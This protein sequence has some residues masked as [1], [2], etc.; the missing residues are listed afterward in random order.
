M[1]LRVF[2]AVL[3]LL[4]AQAFTV[5][6][7]APVDAPGYPSR[8]AD[9]DALPG[10]RNPPAG[11]GQVPFW[12]WSG[13]ALDPERLIWQLRELH[14]KGVSG[15]QV[16][17]SHTDSPGW[18]SDLKGPEIFSE[19]WWE[20]YTKVADECGRLGMGI[21]LSTYTLDWPSGGDNL[22]RKLF[23]DQAELNAIELV[24]SQHLVGA[25]ETRTVPCVENAFAAWAYRMRGG[26]LQ[27]GGTD[28]TGFIENGALTW[29]APTDGTD[30]ADDW[31]VWTFGTRRKGGSL[32]PLM[33]GAGATVVRGFYQQFED[34]NKGSSEGL[35]YFFNDE[36]KIG[37][38]K[39]AW[40]PDFHVE[41]FRRKGY[42]L[43]DVLP[44]MWADMGDVTPKARIDY[45][46]LRMAL[47]EERYFEPIYAWHEKRGIIFGC[48]NHGRGLGPQAY[49]DYFRATRWYSA[50][51]HDTP[52][53][54]AGV[55]KGK[56]SS[57][58]AKLYQRP[59][60]W[61][62]AYHSLGWGATPERLMFATRENYLYGCTLLNLHGL[63]YSTYGSRW[64]WAPPSYHFRM[65]YWKHMGT[66]L[67]YFE[68][69]SYLM[70]QGDAVAD[71]AVI[72]PVTP[73]EAETNG[74]EA[75]DT[76]FQIGRQLMAA[77][78]S[79]DF[80]D[81]QSLSRAVVEDGR[82]LVEDARASYQALVLPNMEAARWSTLEKAAAFS[83]ARGLVLSVGKLPAATDR[84][85]RNDP[86]LAPLL[87]R[88]VAAGRRLGSEGELVRVL[89]SAFV[90]DI[91]GLNGTVRALHRKVGPRDVY[92]VMDAAP[93]DVVE[94]RARGAVELWDAWTGETE[95]LRVVEETASGT[96]VELPLEKYEAQLVVFDP[97]REHVDP[98]QPR[99]T[100]HPL[101][102][103]PDT[104][105]Q[106]AFLPTMD[107]RWGD[108]RLPVTPE[109]R[110]IGVEARRF[111]WL[112]DDAA[113]PPAAEA[114]W[115]SQLHGHGPQMLLHKAAR[116]MT[117][118]QEL[119]LSR[120][121]RPE[122]GDWSPYEFSWRHGVE[123][124]PGH[125]GWHGNKGKVSEHFLRVGAVERS[126]NGI[127]KLAAEEG[128]QS[129]YFWTQAIAPEDCQAV[130]HLSQAAESSAGY[131][132]PNANPVLAPAAIYLNGRRIEDPTRPVRLEA[133]GNSLLVRF[134]GH[135]EGHLVL[136]R[137]D[138]AELEPV[139]ALPLA[140]RWHP[141]LQ[142]SSLIRFDPFVGTT[143]AEPGTGSAQWF[144]FVTAPGTTAITI[145]AAH[146][147]SP[148][149][150]FCDGRPMH[151]GGGGRHRVESPGAGAAIIDLRLTPPLGCHGGAALPEPITI[152]T[153]GRG[154]MALGDWSQRGVLNN[155][156]GA[157]AYTRHL[158]L[159]A[160]EAQRIT[161]LDLGKV[162]ATAELRVNGVEAGVRVAPPWRFDVSGLL[163]AGEN[164]LTVTVYNTL[165]NHYQT[166]PNQYRGQPVAGLF[167]PVRLQGE[168]GN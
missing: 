67:N 110:M 36:L 120:S 52:G 61:L 132:T 127:Q 14:A 140:M 64:E 137:T 37:L 33:A 4:L 168:S 70:S 87:D 20:I 89:R 8:A 43:F 15:V 42:N 58:I 103:L 3:I 22:F 82:L 133:G 157:V 138:H 117:L 60:V 90:Q 118:Q 135:G 16:N 114:E 56:V 6:V 151:A 122:Q 1:K 72:Y 21:G 5:A 59:R 93:G 101:M 66:F 29:S 106:V 125:Q 131:S 23:Y 86:L 164:T 113:T 147:T 155:Y 62:E 53:G 45:A 47:M 136:R 26:L 39:L 109:N 57:S 129:Y 105:W 128:F 49:G 17:Y 85:G 18:P 7:A 95:P 126:I 166:I 24:S 116:P 32:N 10:F 97:R 102:T 25:G 48:D 167:G 71:V 144:R 35:N 41:F 11:Y 98:S 108:F 121:G 38:G 130:L 139:A 44:A 75:T 51:G 63:Y 94:F 12:W 34:R 78:I 46:D 81:H 27:R 88:A 153:S 119:A 99:V 55:I 148:V 100:L 160:D 19:D 73:F 104:D 165:S 40:N 65:P 91:R 69:L 84:V 163:K 96:R 123:D 31:Q 141:W 152:A 54:R 159:S 80:I 92:L 115:R 156:S 28:L 107:N 162:T 77:G 149:Q 76:A 143:A 112:R 83:E 124:D 13:D 134:D 50:P 79:F 161:A 68:R 74:K 146:S 2:S 9:L 111:Q 145:P 142:D 30:G 158:V 154:S 150:A